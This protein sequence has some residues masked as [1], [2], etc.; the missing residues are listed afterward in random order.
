MEIAL[1]QYGSA[2]AE[3]PSVQHLKPLL[4]Y[5][6]VFGV[7]P[8]SVWLLRGHEAPSLSKVH[9]NNWQKTVRKVHHK[10]TESYRR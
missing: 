5:T 3:L 9:K 7:L 4:G 2:Y 1:P 8:I 6:G 10:V